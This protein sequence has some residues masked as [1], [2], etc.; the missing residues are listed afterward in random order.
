M[1]V[2]GKSAASSVAYL[3]LGGPDADERWMDGCRDACISTSF[4]RR[5]ASQGAWAYDVMPIKAKV[6]A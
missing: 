5:G 1:A 6:L 4:A 2:T 3:V